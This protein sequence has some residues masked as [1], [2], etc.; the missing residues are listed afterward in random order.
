MEKISVIIPIYNVEKYLKR[1]LD[2]VLK[3]TYQNI[4]I[5]LI[6]DGSTDTSGL[7][8][9]EYS[10]QYKNINV[11]HKRNEGIGQTRNLGIQMAKGE[12]I[13][14]VDSDDYID[15]N[16]IEQMHLV[17]VNNNCDL[18]CCNKYRIYEKNNRGMVTDEEM[19]P[20]KFFSRK[21]ALGVF[22]LTK[23]VDVVFW[24]KLIKKDL[25][26]GIRCPNGIY[27]DLAT[28]YK[29]LLK[30]NKIANMYNPFY[31]YCQRESSITDEKYN[32]KMIILKNAIDDNY[33]E[34][35]KYYPDLKD[36]LIL[37][38]IHWYT[39]I[40]DKMILNNDFDIALKKEI[41]SMI[42]SNLELIKK[43]DQFSKMKKTQYYL[44]HVSEPIYRMSY[45]L[46]YKLKR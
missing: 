34:I 6:D 44:F 19:E 37:G 5:I 4:E 24:N 9:D 36:N 23:Y 40:Y 41:K 18:V 13:L 21:E 43:S 45:K 46:F 31:Y 11:V 14:F 25:F 15:E 10:K 29:L 20:I 32:E 39:V 35:I 12:Y 17:A 3:Q 42:S 8:A 28:I 22:L 2:S 26:E 33:N 38:K 16:M 1:C 27:E 7:I 30:A